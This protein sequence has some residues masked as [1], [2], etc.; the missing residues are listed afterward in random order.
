[1]EQQCTQEIIELHQF[2]VAWFGGKIPNDEAT[3]AR[4]EQAMG[5]E[6]GIIGPNGRLTERTPLI[7]SLRQ[8][9]GSWQDKPDS[10]IWIENVSLRWETENFALLT[11]EEWQTYDGQTTSRLSSALFQRAPNCPN[12]VE[13]QHLQETWFVN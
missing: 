7:H 9:Y 2:F 11:Y 12:G 1:M 10:K 5:E 13:W 8:G 3:F 6:F 4:F